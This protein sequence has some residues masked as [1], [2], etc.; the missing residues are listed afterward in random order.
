MGEVHHFGD[1]AGI[2]NVLPGAAGT[3]LLNGR[4]VIVEL[5]RDADDVVAFVGEH[6]GG[7]G[8]VHA[9][10]HGDHNPCVAGGFIK[11]E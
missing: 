4:A 8:G 7:D 3:A 1:A 2:I 9:A 6:G 11:A 10:G 5:Q